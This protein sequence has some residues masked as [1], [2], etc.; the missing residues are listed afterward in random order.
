MEDMYY[1]ITSINNALEIS[2]VDPLSVHGEVFYC[3]DDDDHDVEIEEY[4]A[5]LKSE[6]QVI[7]PCSSSDPSSNNNQDEELKD[8]DEDEDE[9]DEVEVEVAA[10]STTQA[11]R[12]T[13]FS[14]VDEDI[15]MLREVE[16]IEVLSEDDDEDEDEVEDEEDD[17]DDVDVESVPI[18]SLA[19]VRSSQY[20]A[21]R[22]QNP[23]SFKYPRVPGDPIRP[24]PKTKQVIYNYE[25]LNKR[26]V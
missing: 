24:D 14:E 21:R 20:G 5:V 6:L 10:P 4:P 18:P 12:R 15:K 9:E 2:E 16:M 7:A 25:H 26:I 19:V 3:D 8:D 13:D 22:I 11:Q 1:P 17:E 23:R